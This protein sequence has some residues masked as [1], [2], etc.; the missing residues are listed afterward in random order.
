LL[1]RRVKFVL[2]IT[3][4][5]A[6]GI[7]EAVIIMPSDTWLVDAASARQALSDIAKISGTILALFTTFIIF[8]LK[9]YLHIVRK[10]LSLSFFLLNYS[11]F[12]L[13]IILSFVEI[14]RIGSEKVPFS[15]IAHVFALFFIALYI[16]AFLVTMAFVE[17]TSRPPKTE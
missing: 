10:Y 5:I 4:L 9:D 14:L 6:G 1:S 15:Q 7:I 8:L 11:I 3:G 12:V 17:I 13:L 16:M 2:F